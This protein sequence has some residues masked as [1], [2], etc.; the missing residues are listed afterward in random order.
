M[1]AQAE[2]SNGDETGIRSF[3]ELLLGSDYWRG[4]RQALE[5]AGRRGAASAR[6]TPK[7]TPKDAKSRPP[8]GSGPCT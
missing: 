3:V 8:K 5:L 7:K 1:L 2:P 4:S 6:A